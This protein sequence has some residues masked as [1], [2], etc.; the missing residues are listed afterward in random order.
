VSRLGATLLAMVMVL[1]V[2]VAG[3]DLERLHADRPSYGDL[4]YLPNGKHLRLASLGQ[5][6]LFADLV[7]LWAIQYYS[8][9]D[10]SDRYRYVQHV[11]GNVIT[12]LD[13]HFV[14]AYWV[15]A[16]ILTIEA[17]DLEGG[18]RLLDKG[19]ESNPDEWV[20][21]YLAGWESYHG[22]QPE[23]ATRYFD[24]AAAVEG[25]PVLVRR[26]RA[27]MA[28]KAGDVRQAA[29]WWTEVLEDETSDAASRAIA[30]RQLR[31]LQSHLHLMILNEAIGAFRERNARWPNSLEELRRSGYITDIPRTSDGRQY[32]YDPSSGAVQPPDGRVFGDS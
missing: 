17:A 3:A 5:D 8:S 31:K 24:Q 14:D 20:L 27:G 32:V 6:T 25:A 12:E 11:F 26:T 22:G 23:R 30:K 4:L 29:K 28:Q 18:L 21:P 15:G 19:I 7:Y 10:R 9:Y 1:A 16:L 2:G 13:P